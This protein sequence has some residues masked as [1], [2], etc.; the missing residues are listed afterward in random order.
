MKLT[1]SEINKDIRGTARKLADAL[2][3]A[4]SADDFAMLA[5]TAEALGKRLRFQSQQRKYGNSQLP[6]AM[7]SGSVL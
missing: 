4:K 1:K 2:K 3:R 6:G 5:R 7:Q